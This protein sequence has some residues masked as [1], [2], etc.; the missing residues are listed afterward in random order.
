MHSEYLEQQSM[1]SEPVLLSYS[2]Q[3]DSGENNLLALALAL[4]VMLAT[5]SW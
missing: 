1:H 2:P 4:G 5:S 3:S